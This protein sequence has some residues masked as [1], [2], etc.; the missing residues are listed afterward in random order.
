[1]N[2]R[3]FLT[4]LGSLLLYSLDSPAEEKPEIFLTIDDGPNVMGKMLERLGGSKA[5]FFVI[6]S[7]LEKDDNY[8]SALKALEDGHQ[9][10]N[11][12]YSHPFF[13]KI[14]MDEVKRQINKTDLLLEELYGEVG[15]ANPRLF[16]FPYGDNGC[17]ACRGENKHKKEIA[18]FLQDEGY[19]EYHWDIDLQDWKGKD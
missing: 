15:K 19:R 14:K 6:G 2:R 7:K 13:S 1:M 5:T 9:L 16:R 10:G 18:D 11:H 12:S 8:R 17:M 4:G 3:T